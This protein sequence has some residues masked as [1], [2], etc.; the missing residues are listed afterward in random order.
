MVAQYICGEGCFYQWMLLWGNIFRK[1]YLHVKRSPAEGA[2]PWRFYCILVKTAQGL[3][4]NLFYNMKS[5]L[6]H[7]VENIKSFLLGRA[8]YN[9]FLATCLQYTGKT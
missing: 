5:V 8:N 6:Q 7:R 3:T 4:K 1:K 9:T 2:L